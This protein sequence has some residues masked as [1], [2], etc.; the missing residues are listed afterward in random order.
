VAQLFPQIEEGVLWLK[1]I[2]TT[3][4]IAKWTHPWT[5]EDYHPENIQET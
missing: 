3:D 4:S 1:C 2:Y 5:A